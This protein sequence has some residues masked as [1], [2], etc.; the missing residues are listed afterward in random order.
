RRFATGARRAPPL[1]ELRA[2]PRL[3]VNLFAWAVVVISLIPFLAVVVLAFMKF[4]GPVLQPGLSL[5][6]FAALFSRSA[7]PL[8]NTL[9]LSTLSAI[10]AAL[11]G[12]PIGYAVTR[13][14]SSLTGLLDVVATMPFAVAGTVLGIALIISFN[15]GPLVL[16]GGWFI[17][18]LAYVVRKLPFSV[19]SSSSILHQIDP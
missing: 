15:S 12:V 5:D 10:G 1:I 4:R 3:L 14:R 16:T 2:G 7:R 17:M 6:N 11:I 19:R 13:F 8:G 9:M 18:V